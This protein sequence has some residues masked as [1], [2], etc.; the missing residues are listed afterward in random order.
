STSARIWRRSCCARPRATGRASRRRAT[1]S[2]W[3]SCA[4]ATARRS[5]WRRR[6][7]VPK[8][9]LVTG[10]GGPSGVS[11]LRALEGE[12]G[13]MV[14][15]DIDPFAAGLYLVDAD[16]RFL[17]P[18]GADP[19]FAPDLLARCA[20]EGIDVVVPTVDTELLPL[21]RMR[22]EF[23]DAGVVLVLASEATL[24]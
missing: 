8:R 3:R 15:A 5:P 13:A 21:A 9:I 14:A 17:V 10:A 16:R 4:T 1:S 6:W 7:P 20:R 23:L 18:R 19:R 11:I 12:P 2:R 24:T 22:E